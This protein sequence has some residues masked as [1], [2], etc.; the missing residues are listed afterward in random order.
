[1]YIAQKKKREEKNDERE[2]EEIIDKR[3]SRSFAYALLGR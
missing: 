2:F 1:M 3:A